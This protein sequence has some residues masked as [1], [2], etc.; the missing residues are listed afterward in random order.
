VIKIRFERELADVVFVVLF[1]IKQ[2]TY[3]EAAFDKNGFKNQ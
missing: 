3:T 2:V 1:V